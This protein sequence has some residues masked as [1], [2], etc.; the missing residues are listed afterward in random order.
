MV[1][2]G[3]RSIDYGSYKVA[4]MNEEDAGITNIEAFSY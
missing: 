1:I 2:Q 3:P 4:S